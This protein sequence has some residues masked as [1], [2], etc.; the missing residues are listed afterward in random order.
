MESR[1]ANMA[2]AQDSPGISALSDCPVVVLD[3]HLQA[4]W[5][6]IYL[7]T[8]G[9][10]WTSNRDQWH[11]ARLPRSGVKV[12][13]MLS[14]RVVKSRSRAFGHRLPV[15]TKT[16]SGYGPHVRS[17]RAQRVT[18]Q[19]STG[20]GLTLGGRLTGWSAGFLEECH[21]CHSVSQSRCHD[22]KM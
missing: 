8:F 19:P 21:N 12:T 6:V 1:G 15:L 5:S 18:S 7:G 17:C 3:R 11:R 20:A 22:R 16:A 9:H 14:N 2:R 13:W 4:R 10:V